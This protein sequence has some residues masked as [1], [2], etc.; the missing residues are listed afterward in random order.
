MRKLARL[1]KD[2]KDCYHHV[3]VCVVC[4]SR[5]LSDMIFVTSSKSPGNA[6]ILGTYGM[7]TH[8]LASQD[9]YF[10]IGTKLPICCF[11]AII[12]KTSVTDAVFAEKNNTQNK[13]SSGF[14]TV[15]MFSM[16]LWH[17]HNVETLLKLFLSIWGRQLRTFF[18]IIAH[19]CNHTFTINNYIEQ[20]NT[21]NICSNIHKN[22]ISSFRPRDPCECTP[23]ASRQTFRN[24][25][26]LLR[27]MKS[28]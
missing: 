13:I 9:T 3:V 28:Y 18:E 25:L 22:R 4:C 24:H 10:L 6:C 20:I 1:I 16:Y 15:D 2:I 12:S 26:L 14:N 21:E 19:L 7:A 8:P 23:S 5:T 27:D 17:V 11:W